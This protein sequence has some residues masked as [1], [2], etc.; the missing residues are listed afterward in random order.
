[1][2][3]P[4]IREKFE[5]MGIEALSSTPEALRDFTRVESERWGKLVREA[6]IRAD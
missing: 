4:E 6:N 1:M 5:G 2:T 3:A